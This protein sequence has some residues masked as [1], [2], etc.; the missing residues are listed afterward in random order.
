[1]ASASLWTSPSSDNPTKATTSCKAERRSISFSNLIRPRY[2]KRSGN[3][4]VEST[5]RFPPTRLAPRAPTCSARLRLRLSTTFPISSSPPWNTR[6]LAALISRS[7]AWLSSSTDSTQSSR[8]PRR[9]RGKCG[10]MTAQ[11]TIGAKTTSS[12]SSAPRRSRTPWD[13]QSKAATEAAFR[14]LL[15]GQRGLAK[16]SGTSRPCL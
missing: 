14:L 7:S 2:W 3:W 4:G 5:S 12:N 6:T 10:H 11:V 9:N 15:S 13:R 16:P 1:M 8:S